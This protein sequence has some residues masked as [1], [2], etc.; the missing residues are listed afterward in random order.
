M[1]AKELAKQWVQLIQ[2]ELTQHATK[3]F[4]A[5]GEDVSR[6]SAYELVRATCV[7]SPMHD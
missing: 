1:A 5:L 7:H 2:A 4:T 3:V 6:H